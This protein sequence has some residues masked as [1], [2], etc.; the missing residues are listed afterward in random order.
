MNTRIR[1]GLIFGAS[2]VVAIALFAVLSPRDGQGPMDWLGDF[3]QA[4]PAQKADRLAP[5]PA[6]QPDKKPPVPSQ[7]NS[8]A[9]TAGTPSERNAQPNTPPASP[10]TTAQTPP[11]QADA[12]STS[13]GA[14]R[15][16]AQ[17]TAPRATFDI[18]R[19]EPSG[20][21]VIAGRCSPG[22]SVELLTNGRT[23]DRVVADAEGS[24]S[25]VP[26]PLAPGDHVLS[27]RVRTPDG[28]VSM[29]EQTVTVSMPQPPSREVVVVLNAPGQ[30]SRV[31]AMPRPAE[32][33]TVVAGE[34]GSRPLTV[35][36]VDAEGGRFFVQGSAPPG[37]LLRIYLNGSFIAA[38]VASSA[39]AW[40]LRVDHGL[41]PGEYDLRVDQVENE[42]GRVVS[43]ALA[44][45]AYRAEVAAAGSGASPSFDQATPL[46][47]S[48]AATLAQTPQPA[49]SAADAVVPALD[50]VTVK[51]GDSLWSISRR[52]Y[53]AGQRYTVIFAANGGQIRNPNLIYPGQI[54]VMPVGGSPN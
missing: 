31:L 25:M 52:S 7:P 45:F 9:P 6:P 48:N 39:G 22:C 27:L 18:V 49:A 40:S 2:I 44:R 8:A 3:T 24:W 14:D 12:P 47:G 21:S 16:K 28:Q 35:G 32:K 13:P 41:S 11:A 34:T 53:G 33:P 51:R 36:A 46:T 4:P 43:R 29:S 20:D 54:F 50:S 37:A 17:D 30:P 38:P 5:P 42:A 10:A 23:H 15:G 19:V 26:P 1:T